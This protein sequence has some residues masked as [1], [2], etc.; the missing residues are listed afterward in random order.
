M[1]E[2]VVWYYMLNNVDFQSFKST[3]NLF[4]DYFYDN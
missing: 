1:E 2:Q 4:Y 3:I